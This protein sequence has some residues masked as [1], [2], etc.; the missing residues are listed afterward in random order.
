MNH[1]IAII[2]DD[3]YTCNEKRLRDGIRVALNHES[4]P[5]GAGL[6][7]LITDNESVAA[8]NRQFRGI[9]APTDVLSF[10]AGPDGATTSESRYL[11]DLAIAYPYA[12]QQASRQR[13][14]IDDSL[15][16]LVVHGVLHL[17]GYDHDTPERREKMW[18]AQSAILIA[19]GLSTDLVPSMEGQ[20]PHV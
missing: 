16:L 13:H 7:V 17:L 6:S 9:D 8:L 4:A 20:T 10:P 12:Y 15:A 11:G 1:D 14:D 5:A 19:L 18:T 2:N 3:G